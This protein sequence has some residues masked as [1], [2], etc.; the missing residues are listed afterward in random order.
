MFDVWIIA[1]KLADGCVTGR[2]V[3]LPVPFVVPLVHADI[4]FR[5]AR[6]LALG[7]EACVVAARIV[8]TQEMFCLQASFTSAFLSHLLLV[9][10]LV[11]LLMGHI[12]GP[13]AI[14]EASGAAVHIGTLL[15]TR[16][17]VR[18]REILVVIP[19]VPFMMLVII[20]VPR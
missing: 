18:I 1:I 16:A 7:I 10:I 20:I 8:V 14:L 9:L 5:L 19:F 17:T 13:S 2:A 11:Q 15:P 12:A 3:A 4:Q 6:R